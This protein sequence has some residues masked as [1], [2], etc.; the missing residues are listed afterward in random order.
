MIEKYEMSPWPISPH[1]SDA[2]KFRFLRASVSLW[3]KISESRC[4]F[5]GDFGKMGWLPWKFFAERRCI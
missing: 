2:E 1:A 3:F 4:E 5:A